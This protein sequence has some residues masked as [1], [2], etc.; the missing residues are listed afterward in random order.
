MAKSKDQEI[1]APGIEKAKNE[2]KLAVLEQKNDNLKAKLADYKKDESK[3]KWTTFKK[4][5]NHD[6]AELGKAF[7]DFTVKNTK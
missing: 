4:E 5:F 1:P 7:K 6:M 2:K 3:D